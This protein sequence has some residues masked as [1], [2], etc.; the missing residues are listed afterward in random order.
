MAKI[1]YNMFE[2]SDY[3]YKLLTINNNVELEEFIRLYDTYNLL[4]NYKNNL[5]KISKNIDY[6]EGQMNENI[7]RNARMQEA[8]FGGLRDGKS[9]GIEI[10]ISQGISQILN[11]LITNGKSIE[12]ISEMTG[13]TKEEIKSYDI[14]TNIKK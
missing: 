7:E 9:E 12:E 6:E 11:A 14:N 13:L 5:V 2:K 1:N 3:F 4:D 10:G 8:Y